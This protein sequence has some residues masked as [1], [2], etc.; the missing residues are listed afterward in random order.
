MAVQNLSIVEAASL[1]TKEAAS[2]LKSIG[3]PF[4][5]GTLEVW[6]CQGRGPRFRRV[7]R[8]IFYT[9]EDLDQ[10]IQGQVVETID[11]INN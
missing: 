10:F 2:Y 8:K 1:S 3:T 5:A 6:R 4:S 7:N 11:S 9:K